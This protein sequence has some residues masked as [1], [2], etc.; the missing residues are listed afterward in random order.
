[1]SGYPLGQPLVQ[2]LPHIITLLQIILSNI[3]SMILIS[4]SLF[5]LN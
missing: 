1:M 5:V 2:S 3:A 4:L